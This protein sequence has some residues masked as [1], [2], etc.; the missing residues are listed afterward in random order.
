MQ[1]DKIQTRGMTVPLVDVRK[2]GIIETLARLCPGF[3]ITVGLRKQV[4][5]IEH[6]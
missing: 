6:I 3:L 1:A 2:A 5:W 4:L